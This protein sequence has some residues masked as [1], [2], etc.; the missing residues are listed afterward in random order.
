M[1]ISL[2]CSKGLAHIQSG[3]PVSPDPSHLSMCPVSPVPLPVLGNGPALHTAEPCL[4]RVR[5]SRS[6][7]PPRSVSRLLQ[8]SAL[9]AGGRHTVG[10][11]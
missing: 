2:S 4:P 10:Y 7:L 9:D 11:R 8:S 3:P 6:V 5:P 1:S